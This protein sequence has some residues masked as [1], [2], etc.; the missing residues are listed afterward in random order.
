MAIAR[1]RIVSE[2]F[3]SQDYPIVTHVFLGQALSEAVGYYN[4]HLQ[5]DTFLASRT[6]TEHFRNFK[7]TT[8]L[9]TERWNGRNWVAVG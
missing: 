4:A 6:N 7:C 9:R 2:I 3:E 5:T 1:F 8:T